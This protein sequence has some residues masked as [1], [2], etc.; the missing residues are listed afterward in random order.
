MARTRT[1]ITEANLEK[2]MAFMEENLNASSRDIAEHFGRGL[3][4]GMAYRTAADDRFV[5]NLNRADAVFEAEDFMEGIDLRAHLA[6][7]AAEA[8][9]EWH[10]A[11][12]AIYTLTTQRDVLRGLNLELVSALQRFVD[13]ERIGGTNTRSA[14][15]YCGMT[16]PHYCA[17]VDAEAALKHAEEVLK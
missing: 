4:W 5:D 2:V 12:R 15:S 13:T 10:F 11:S 14:C 8:A 7:A 6:E 3:H 1:R 17:L 16:G 9:N